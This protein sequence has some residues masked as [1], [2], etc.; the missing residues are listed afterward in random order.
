MAVCTVTGDVPAA[1]QRYAKTGA[2]AVSRI[3]SDIYEALDAKPR[4]ALNGATVV[5]KTDA[6]AY[7]T[8]TAPEAGKA[9]G[10]V[11]VSSGFLE[12]VNRLAHAKAID[13]FNK[14]YLEKYLAGLADESKDLLEASNP[15]YWEAGVMDEQASNFSQMVGT[16]LALE[17]S[18]H[19]LGHYQKYAGKLSGN[20]GPPTPINLLLAPDEWSASVRAGVRNCLGAGLG[21]EGI[22]A[23]VEAMDKLPKR[24]AWAAFCVPDNI[25][26]KVLRKE[27]EKIERKFFGGEE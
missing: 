11:V 2:A 22:K 21:I 26:G 19:Y 13:K 20:G 16:L 9:S 18:H 1:A 8:Q 12:L 6:A 23:L 17:Y 10:A 7:L 25:K 5:V 4:Q 24:P 27:M 3:G 15:R 14:G